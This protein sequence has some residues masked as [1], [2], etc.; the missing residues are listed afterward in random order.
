MKKRTLQ[1]VISICGLLPWLLACGCHADPVQSPDL[2]AQTASQ[3]DSSPQDT[4]TVSPDD[5]M[6]CCV[7]LTHPDSDDRDMIYMFFVDQ[8]G[9]VFTSQ[10]CND[11]GYDFVR[12]KALRDPDV[13]NQA[14]PLQEIGS[15]SD[16][17]LHNLADAVASV[18]PDADKYIRD[19]EEPIPDVLETYHLMYSLYLPDCPTVYTAYSAGA[20]K[21]VSLRSNDPNAIAA[22]DIIN[23]TAL[24]QQW[25]QSNL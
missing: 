13:F 5:A 8:N 11:K 17:E 1:N 4:T 23:D 9:A 20:Q 19:S 24:F 6:L 10:Y 14:D 18:D 2:S 7:D 25:L 12:K 16:Q 22:T 15:L 3:T 21:G